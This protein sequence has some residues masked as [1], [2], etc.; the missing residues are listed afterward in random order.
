MP[1]HPYLHDIFQNF[2]AYMGGVYGKARKKWVAVFSMYGNLLLGQR[3]VQFLGHILQARPT[4]EGM[5]ESAVA[6][7]DE[8]VWNGA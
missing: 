4:A 2:S 3:L 7:V 5:N 1:P 8:I 6:A